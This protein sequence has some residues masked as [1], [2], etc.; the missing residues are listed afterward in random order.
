MYNAPHEITLVLRDTIEKG[1]YIDIMDFPYPDNLVDENGLFYGEIVATLVTSPYLDGTQGP[2]YCQTD[3]MLSMGTYDS[4]KERDLEIATVRNP[5][6]RNNPHNVLLS[7]HYQ[8]RYR[9]GRSSSGFSSE[10]Q[11]R[12]ESLKYHPVKKYAVNLHEM[13]EAHRMRSLPSARKWYLQLKSLANYAAEQLLSNAELAQEFCLIITISD[14]HKQHDIYSAVTRN[15]D[16]FSFPHSNIKL[17][18]ENRI[19][20]RNSFGEDHEV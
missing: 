8:A 12:D 10:R 1:K 2:E 15:L 6:G 16:R 20:L 13:T 5:Y 3:V 17:H 9:K 7:S 14:P 11:L 19:D 18:N 4:I